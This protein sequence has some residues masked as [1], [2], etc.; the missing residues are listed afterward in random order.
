[1]TTDLWM[2]VASGALALFISSV[3][4]FRAMRQTWGFEGLVGNREDLPPLTGWGARTARAYNN[5]LDN[6]ILFGAAVILAHIT[7]SANETTALMSQVFFAARVVHAVTYIAG[8]RY[9]RTVAYLVSAYAIFKI[10]MQLTT[11]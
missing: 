4:L 2:L 3:P 1:M 10:A 7:G 5:L 11:G 9:V 8:I 6:I